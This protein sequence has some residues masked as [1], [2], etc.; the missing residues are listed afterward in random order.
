M[1]EIE[2]VQL[3][4]NGCQLFF[5]L[6]IFKILSL[7]YFQRL[8]CIS[9]RNSAIT[10]TADNLIR[11]SAPLLSSSFGGFHVRIRHLLVCYEI[12]LAWAL[13]FWHPTGQR[14]LAIWAQL[15]DWS[16]NQSTHN[17]FWV[18]ITNENFMIVL[19]IIISSN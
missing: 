4:Q 6:C 19:T 17:L 10:M 18:T 15:H 5:L 11:V 8:C 3:L 7:Q 16:R 1:E 12:T 2:F 9:Q 14:N 13:S